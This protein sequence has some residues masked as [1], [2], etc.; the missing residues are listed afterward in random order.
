MKITEKFGRMSLLTSVAGN[1]VHNQIPM[2]H[3]RLI[4]VRRPIGLEYINFSATSLI[5]ALFSQ[6]TKA[7]K[8]ADWDI[9][10]CGK[11]R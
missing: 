8:P 1:E 5:R 11:L 2:V 10:W 6:N 4:I 9:Y 3:T 7:A